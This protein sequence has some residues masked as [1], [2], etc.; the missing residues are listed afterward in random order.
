RRVGEMHQQLASVM[1]ARTLEPEGAAAADIVR[2]RDAAEARAAALERA[3]AAT[4]SEIAEAHER[5]AMMQLDSRDRV[6]WSSGDAGETDR[7]GAEVTRLQAALDE[8]ERARSI[9]EHAHG[10]AMR[11]AQVVRDELVGHRKA[12]A[13]EL[14]AMRVELARARES[15]AM[16]EAVA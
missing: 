7:M 15:R 8:A 14:E 1:S 2:Q 4:R 11:E 5:I 9:A 16:A 10:E 6:T 13:V 12:S 3:L